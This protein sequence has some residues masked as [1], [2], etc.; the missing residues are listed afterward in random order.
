MDFVIMLEIFLLFILPILLLRLKL[1]PRKFRFYMYIFIILLI[2]SIFIVE[3]WSFY[4]I[5]FRLD[6]IRSAVLPYSIFTILSILGIVLYAHLLNR[7]QVKQ[8]WVYPH[9]QYGFLVLAFFQQIAFQSFLTHQ[10]QILNMN[11]L[12]IILIVTT[13]FLF[14][15]TIFNSFKEGIPLLIVA[16]IVYSSFYLIYQNIIIA[17]LSHAVLN[18]ISVLYGFFIDPK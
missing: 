17:T 8:W 2:F 4:Q 5:G 9:F 13:I 15:H 7:K 16:G 18:F 6:N 1:V 14:M 3:K 11:P 10:L 12:V